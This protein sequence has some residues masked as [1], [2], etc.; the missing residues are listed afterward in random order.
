AV[1]RRRRRRRGRAAA[2]RPRRGRRGRPRGTAPG[3]RGEGVRAIVERPHG[4]HRR[5]ARRPREG[6]L[7]LRAAWNALK[8][9]H[10]K[11]GDL[12]LRQL[13]AG[14]PGRGERM[15]AEAAGVDLDYS[16]NRITDETLGL[17]VQLAKASGLRARID[18]MFRGD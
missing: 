13:F 7:T 15:T 16:K 14:D 1:A 10:E 11:I 8:A 12:H 6:E 2:L 4:G 3:R 9:H 17:L 5:Q 18:A